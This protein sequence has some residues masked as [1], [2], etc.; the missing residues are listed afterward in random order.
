MDKTPTPNDDRAGTFNPDD[1]RYNPPP[2][3]DEDDD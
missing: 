2:Y 3:D 1:H